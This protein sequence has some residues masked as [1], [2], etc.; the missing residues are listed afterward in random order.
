MED[1][2]SIR[3]HHAL[4]STQR[5]PHFLD[6]LSLFGFR[7]AIR[8]RIDLIRLYCSLL[9]SAEVRLVRV[10]Y[11]ISDYNCELDRR[12]LTP[13]NKKP[14]IECLSCSILAAHLRP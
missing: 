6:R 4:P 5:T 1:Y 8:H 14:R 12:L 9:S 10:R 11:S 2:D 3:N 13:Q 7:N